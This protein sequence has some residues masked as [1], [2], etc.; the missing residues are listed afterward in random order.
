[1]KSACLCYGLISTVEQWKAR[2]RHGKVSAVKSDK[3]RIVLA[4]AMWLTTPAHSADREC[5][6]LVKAVPLCTA[7]ADASQYDGKEITV[8]GLYRMVIHGFVLMS[9]ECGKDLVNM[10]LASDHKADKHASAEIRKVT[11][12]DQFQSVDVVLRGTFRVAGKGECFGQNCLLYEIE[13]HELYCAKE[14]KPSGH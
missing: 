6:A 3:I 10:R 12:K 5:P 13:E 2:L 4:L 9:P 1:M 11:R 14:A 7:L 8:R